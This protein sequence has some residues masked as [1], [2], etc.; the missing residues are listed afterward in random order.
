MVTVGGYLLAFLLLALLFVYKP[1][2]LNKAKWAKWWHR[3]AI[4]TIPLTYL[5][6]ASGW[7]VAEVGRQPWTIQDLMPNKVAISDL[8]AGY[9]QTTFWIFAVVFTALLIADIGI[10]CKQISKKS[11]TDLDTVND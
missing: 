4:I 11:Q 9:V 8:S 3:L 6:S 5:C 1:D 2:I 7:I 10:I